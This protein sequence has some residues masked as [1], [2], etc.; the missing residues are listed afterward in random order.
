MTEPAPFDDVT[1][2]DDLYAFI[3]D[4][5]RLADAGRSR[6]VLTRVRAAHD[7]CHFETVS[8]KTVRRDVD[9]VLSALDNGYTFEDAPE[10]F[11]A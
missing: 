1:E 11:A 4:E 2:K 8:G 5:L 7:F 9:E 3:G 6:G 10:W